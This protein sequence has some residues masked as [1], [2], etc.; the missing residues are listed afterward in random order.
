MPPTISLSS[1]A[2]PERTGASRSSSQPVD[3]SE[4]QLRRCNSD[5]VTKVIQAPRHS[6]STPRLNPSSSNDGNNVA[7]NPNTSSDSN[8]NAIQLPPRD[9]GASAVPPIPPDRTRRSTRHRNYLSRNTLHSQVPARGSEPCPS[10]TRSTLRSVVTLPGGYEMRTTSQGQIYFY[11]KESEVTTWYDPRVPRELL[12]QN[13]N[14]DELIGPLP[15]GWEKRQF[16]S[17]KNRIYFVDHNNKTTQFTDPRLVANHSRLQSLV[18]VSDW[19]GGKKEGFPRQS[20]LEKMSFLR[21]E[22]SSQQPQTGH[23]RLEVSREQIFEESYRGIMKMRTKDLKK[24]LMVKFKGEEGLD[25]G[26]VAR[27]WLFLLSHEMLNPSYGLF[28]YTREDIY[29]LQINPNSAVNPVRF[30]P[31]SIC[32]F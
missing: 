28:Q 10:E 19:K 26:G 30:L 25:Y 11:H 5:H 24:R 3:S 4:R 18:K 17:T 8:Q 32:W 1:P 15:P 16:N 2:I 12:H 13:L 31:T 21:Q 7:N 22:L 6:S 9:S 23:C 20:L 14:L 29:T 27:E